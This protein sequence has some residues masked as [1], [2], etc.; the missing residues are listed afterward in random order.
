MTLGQAK[1]GSGAGRCAEA[2]VVK[3][4]WVGEGLGTSSG[5]ERG[6]AGTGQTSVD[7]R[8]STSF[9]ER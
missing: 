3:G 2:D 8:L 6:L 9:F 4:G 7:M 1:F 5:Q